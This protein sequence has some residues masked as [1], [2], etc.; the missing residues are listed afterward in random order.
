MR[1]MLATLVLLSAAPA[2][3]DPLDYGR[4]VAFGDSLSDN[5]NLAHNYPIPGSPPLLPGYYNGRFSTGPTWIELLSNP[6]LSINPDSSMNRF[7][8]GSLFAPPYDTGSS[9]Y[10]VDAAIGGPKPPQASRHQFRPRLVHSQRQG[11]P[12]PPPTL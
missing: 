6:T 3:A 1:V 7:W 5:G 12:L 4:I 2:L 10:N 8:A 11:A 9:K